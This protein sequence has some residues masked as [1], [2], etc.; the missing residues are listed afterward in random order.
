MR[1]VQAL[2]KREELLQLESA[3]VLF[4]MQNTRS[5][6]VGRSSIE[7]SGALFLISMRTESSSSRRPSS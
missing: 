2:S 3:I 7:K 5:W 6:L 4:G 1:N